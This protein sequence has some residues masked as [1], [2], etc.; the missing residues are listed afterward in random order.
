MRKIRKIHSFL[1]EVKNLSE[2]FYKKIK[3]NDEL[4][5]IIGSFPRKNTVVM[6]RG[7]FDIVHPGHLRQFTF[8]K[9][10]GD[11]LMVSITADKY[12]KKRSISPYVP[13]E[14]R[15]LNLA[16]L[17]IVDY[18]VIDNDPW[19]IGQILTLRPNY[20]V[21]GH[22]YALH[23]IHPKTKEEIDT[24]ATY[25]G[26]M[27]FSPGDIVYS[28]SRYLSAN[29]PNLS[30]DQLLNM[31][32]MEKLNFRKLRNTIKGFRGIKVHVVGDLIVDKYTT[33]T[34]LGPSQKSPAFSVRQESYENFVGGAGI[35]AKHLKSLGADVTFTTIFGKDEQGKLALKDLKKS[36]IKVNAI[37]E[38]DRPTTVK[39]RYL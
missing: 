32:R 23:G 19:A 13:Q 18:V 17:E 22:E 3:T 5:K 8:A 6:C 31:M 10:K 36:G 34:I 26:K 1:Q 35:V 37:Y 27:L 38:K 28:S 33:C 24:L 4:K 14:L 30:V 16:M 25:G 9:S 29:K 12:I 20:Y 39:E 21:K 7:V 15:A 2:H 11:I